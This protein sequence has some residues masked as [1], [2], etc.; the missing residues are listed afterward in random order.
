[1]QKRDKKKR[2]KKVSAVYLERAAFAYL[3][4]F[5]SSRANLARVLANKVRR[6]HE[7]F[8]P[9][10]EEEQDWIT[11]VAEKCEQLGL[12]DDAQ[13]AREKTR[14]MHRA[15]RSARRINGYL[16]SKGVGEP[17]IAAAFDDL[18]SEGD[19]INP[20]LSAAL[21]YARKRR[22]GP[23]GVLKVNYR[24]AGAEVD[25]HKQ[26]Q[27]ELGSFARAGFSLNIALK[28]LGCADIEA[29][30]ALLEE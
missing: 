21:S 23:Y 27:K 13:Y 26:R 17:L 9:P 1:M 30:E 22:L 29:A 2:I 20:D 11:A 18:V 6:R 28:I 14:S 12:V 24:S 4:R 8:S 25:P 19:G 15:G 3:G 10:G 5:A 7:D 16:R